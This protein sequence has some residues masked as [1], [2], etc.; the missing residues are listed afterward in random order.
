M[1]NSVASLW[2]KVVGN[3]K[4]TVTPETYNLWIVPLKPVSL[5]NNV[6]TLEVPNIYFS[7]WITK[8]QQRNIEQIMSLEC[9]NTITLE[10]RPQHNLSE[11]IKKAEETPEH[12][13]DIEV[14][15]Q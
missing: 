15:T 2:E 10:F 12:I 13:V 11:T 3:I 14:S 1:S 8:N 4:S 7:Q 6:F 5:E 9:G